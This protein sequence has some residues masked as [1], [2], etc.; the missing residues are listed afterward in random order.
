M[1]KNL[2]LKKMAQAINKMLATDPF[3]LQQFSALQEKTLRLQILKTPFDFLIIFHAA[4]IE[5]DF[6]TADDL[7]TVEMSG[8]PTSLLRFAKTT[9][10]TQMLMDKKIQIKGDLDLLMQ[11]KKIQQQIVIDWE[12]LCAEYL[13]EFF[14]DRLFSFAKIGKEKISDHL[15]Q[16]QADSLNYLHDELQLLPTEAEI[17]DFYEDIRDLRRDI[18]RLD[19][20]LKK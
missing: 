2:A 5:L 19:R 15:Q 10:Q 20:C 3:V 1:F 8:T 11:I 16:F 9:E 17:H 14:S 13:G 6:F 12:G 7:A 4:G 18:D